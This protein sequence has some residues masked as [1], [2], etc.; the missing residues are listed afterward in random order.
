MC[1]ITMAS[2]QRKKKRKKYEDKVHIDKYLYQ[3][4]INEI[5]SKKEIWA[6]DW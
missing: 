6:F 3:A 1:M 2:T 4:D 5:I